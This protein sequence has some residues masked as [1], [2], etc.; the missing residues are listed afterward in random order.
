MPKNLKWKIPVIVI[1]I[2][3]AIFA[4]Y[5]PGDKVIKSEE[6]KE[7]DGK[8]ISR[9]VI[10]DSAFGFLYRNPI[11]KETILKEETDEK[12]LSVVHKNVEYVARGQIGF[13]Q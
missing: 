9:S 5:P 6:V 4:L 8:V 7:V 11:I 12:G 10:K 2:A 3:I 13:D 1:L